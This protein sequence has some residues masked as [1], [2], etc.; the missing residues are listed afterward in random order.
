MIL[1]IYQIICACIAALIIRNLFKSDAPQEK[2]V[3]AFIL[4]PFAL[5]ALLL[6]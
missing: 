5:R 1:V 2:I 6:K 3:Y 4:I